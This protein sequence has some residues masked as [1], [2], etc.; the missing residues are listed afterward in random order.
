MSHHSQFRCVLVRQ[1][2]GTD[3]PTLPQLD[4][5]EGRY[6]MNLCRVDCP[7]GDRTCSDDCASGACSATTELAA[8]TVDPSNPGHAR[9]RCD[10]DAVPANGA[11]G[12]AAVAYDGA[13]AGYQRGCIDEWEP[14][15]GSASTDEVAAWR[16][17]CPGWI[18]DPVG[19]IGQGDPAN[20]GQLQ[21][22]CGDHY[23]G[24]NCD[25]GCPEAQLNLSE[26][27]SS[28]PR[29]GYWMCADFTTTSYSAPDPTFGPALV[30]HD[31]SGSTY[32]MRDDLGA[33]VDGQPLCEFGADCT[34]GFVIR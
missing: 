4:F 34:T 13:A 24:P 12:L 10:I 19:S 7:T 16:S 8:G 20:F 11:V 29:A 2:A 6:A 25:L 26:G 5:T 3:T 28:T 33:P 15:T 27:Y 31:A 32:I 21:C 1:T 22:G 17:L 14:T 18:A 30:G 9:L 23:G